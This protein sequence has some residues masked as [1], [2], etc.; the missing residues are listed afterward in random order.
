VEHSRCPGIEP[1]IL[2]SADL[3]IQPNPLGDIEMNIKDLEV[4]KELSHEERAVRGGANVNNGF[5]FGPSLVENAGPSLFSPNTTVLIA[6]QEQTQ[7]NVAPVTTTVDV[8]KIASVL[9][10]LGTSIGQ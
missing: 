6:P 3:R 7:I 5:I 4:A 1:S 8:S 9:G 10:S 2:G